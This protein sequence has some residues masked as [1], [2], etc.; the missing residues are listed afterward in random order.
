MS[1]RFLKASLLVM[2]ASL[3]AGALIAGAKGVMVN[4]TSPTT[5]WLRAVDMMSTDDGWAVGDG[6]TIIR[7]DGTGWNW[8]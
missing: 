7:R 5:A 4:W 3:C 8:V 2:T 1:R 6:S